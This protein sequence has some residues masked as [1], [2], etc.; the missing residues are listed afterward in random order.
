MADEQQQMLD[1]YL[2]EY[3][4]LK[5]EQAQRIGFR[6][7]LLYVTLALFGTVLALAMGGNANPYALLVLPWASLVLGWTYLVNDWKITAIGQ[8]I[9]YTL[10]DTFSE[11]EVYTGSSLK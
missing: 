10:P 3:G 8:Y 4:K 11:V 7:N 1:V 5:D 6:D 9:R 2:Q